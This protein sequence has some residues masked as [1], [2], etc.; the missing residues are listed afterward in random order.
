ML[1][2]QKRIPA[3]L[4]AALTGIFLAL[5]VRHLDLSDKFPV[6]RA[7]WLWVDAKFRIRGERPAGKEV[8]IVGLDEKTLSKLGSARVFK[9][10]NFA[11]LIRKLS[12]AQPKAIGL[13]I[14]F[15]EADVSDAAN[16]RKFAE[17]IRAADSVVL[18]IYLYLEDK[19]GR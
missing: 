13:D 11:I 1:T 17:A 6:T 5:A 12:A 14:N 7:D 15:P 8:V 10:D 2:L 9:R 18:G 19:T 3:L 16:D 4:A